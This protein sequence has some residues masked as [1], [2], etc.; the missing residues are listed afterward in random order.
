MQGLILGA[1]GYGYMIGSLPGGHIAEWLGPYWVIEVAT[2]ASAVLNSIC[3]WVTPLHWGFL[4]ALRLLIGLLAV[5]IQ[6]IR[7]FYNIK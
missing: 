4:F 3:V 5:S 6:T 7:S 1:Y 2:A